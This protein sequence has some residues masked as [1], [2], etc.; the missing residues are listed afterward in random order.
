MG[1]GPHESHESFTTSPSTP[2]FPYQTAVAFDSALK[3]RLAA[4]AANSPYELNE[5]RRQFAYDRLLVRIFDHE[6]ESW[7]LKGG[8]GLLARLPGQARHSMDLD[9]YYAGKLATAIEDLQDLGADETFGD[10]FTFVIEPTTL[11]MPGHACALAVTASIGNKIF[12]EFSIDLVVDTNMTQPPDTVQPL[13]P[14]DIVGL[15]SANYRVY[16]L[17]DHIADKHA[18]MLATYQGNTPSSRHRD[19]VDLVLIATTQRPHA[20]ELRT[21]LLSEYANR[22][23]VTPATVELPHPS[24]DAGY[25]KAASKLHIPQTASQG[26]DVCRKMLEPILAGRITGTWNPDNLE[27]HD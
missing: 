26:L 27:W 22:N 1:S 10:F 5:L 9:M 25:A 24:W 11:P 3:A 2:T 7:V 20:S 4:A 13:H 12:Q 21:A 6:P 16:A 8:G 14:A 18:A 17:V 15:R 19:L 23:L